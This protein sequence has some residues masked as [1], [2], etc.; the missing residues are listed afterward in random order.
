MGSQIR[1]PKSIRGDAVGLI[2]NTRAIHAEING[3]SKIVW[4][5]GTGRKGEDRKGETWKGENWKGKVGARKAW[6]GEDWKRKNWEGETCKIGSWKARKRKDW[7]GK[8]IGDRK[9]TKGRVTETCQRKIKARIKT[10]DLRRH[11]Y[12]IIDLRREA[13]CWIKKIDRNLKIKDDWNQEIAGIFASTA[14]A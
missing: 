1:I 6:K 9:K 2:K 4:K 3:G 13:N 12:E 7:K 11:P 10:Y 14:K 5:R 8:T